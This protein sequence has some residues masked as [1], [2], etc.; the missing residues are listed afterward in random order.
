MKKF[1][2]G[3]ISTASIG[4]NHVIPAMQKSSTIEVAAISSR[5]LAVAQEAATRLRIPAA[6]GS[7]EE[8]LADA[9]LDAIYNPLPNHLHAEWSAKAADAGKHVLCE[10]PLA[11][12]SEEAQELHDYFAAKGLVLNEAFMYR[13]HPR[14]KKVK[15]LVDD[16]AIGELVSIHSTF[17]YFDDDP[18]NIRAVWAKGGGALMDIGC[19]PISMAR[20]LTGS[21]PEVVGAALR[22]ADGS[23]VDTAGAATL[24]FGDVL[25]TF[26]VSTRAGNEQRVHISGSSGRIDIEMPYNAPVD[27]PTYIA[28]TTQ[29]GREAVEIPTTDQYQ[30][31]GEAFAR[32]VTEG[33]PTAMS[34]AD[35]VG[36]MRVID[37]VF[38]L[39]GAEPLPQVWFNR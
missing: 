31:Q 32:A 10:K 22:N 11:M 35:T 33:E 2:F 30:I 8:L 39:A 24:A 3:I 20:Y 21:E 16:G 1:R 27:E 36:N 38:E 9:T 19:Y 6:Y 29:A 18:D 17:C 26:L 15:Q 25:A 5:N 12:N 7:Y 28:I 4:L 13:T 37:K 23:E 34:A 14:W